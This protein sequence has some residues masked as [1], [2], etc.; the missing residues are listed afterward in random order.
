VVV[1]DGSLTASQT[2]TV[3]VNEVNVAPVLAPI[4]SK[5]VN[6]LTLLTFTATATDAD[7]PVQTLTFSLSGTV[8]AGASITSAGVFTW[9]PTEA[10]GP[11]DYTFG[12]VVSDGSLTASQTVT[13]HVN[14]VNVAPVLAPIGS[15]TV[16]VTTLLTF[17]ATATDADI[18][19]QTLTFS[20]SGTV[21]AGASITSAGVF[22]WT[23][24]AVQVGDY[25]FGVVVS[26]GSLTASETITVQVKGGSPPPVASFVV[27]SA[28]NAATVTVD[29][30][31]S[32]SSVGIASYAWNWGDSVIGPSG[33][34]ASH[35][36]LAG[37]S[38]TITLT[39]TDTLGQKGTLSKVVAVKNSAIPP[40]PFTLFGTT[41]ASDGVT[42]LAGC[43]ITITDVRTGT[44]LVD[45]VSD[46]TGAFYPDIS[47]LLIVAGDTIIVRAIGPAG[48]TGSGTGIVGSEPYLGIDVTLT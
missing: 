19:V 12:V 2:V 47:P 36:Y 15:K 40:P 35:Y 20:L 3:H 46:E 42:P 8:P 18:P 41:W 16:D 22:T 29:A 7:I 25:T 1:S 9:T 11:G 48:Q 27:T 21:P 31:A 14:E 33:V 13:V 6:E 44:T 28:A 10:Q 32:T 26:D 24:S 34:T 43:T 39:V 45:I 38:Y 37:A 23:P 5:T 17:T 4:G 30:S